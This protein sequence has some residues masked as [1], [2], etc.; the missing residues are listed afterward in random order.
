M[1]DTPSPTEP[2]ALPEID[3]SVP[4]PARMYDYIL[5]GTNNYPADQHMA[6]QLFGAVGMPAARGYARANRLFLGRAVRY[7]VGQGIR[8]FLDVGT[9]I[10][11]EDNVHGVAQQAASDSRIVYV[12]NDPLV[13]VHANALLES[14]SDGA[15]SYISGDLRDPESILL[16]AASTLD[17]AEPV[18]VML[19]GIL[20]MIG[21]EDDPMGIVEELMAAVPSGSYLAMTHMTTDVEPDKMTQVANLSERVDKPLPFAVALRPREGIERF[22]EGLAPVEPGMVR[23]DQWRPEP[24]E[25]TGDV[26]PIY[27][28]VARKP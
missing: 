19:I 8:Q 26:T 1:T 24:D 22:L 10:P 14:T 27:G 23:V 21:D 17:F 6:E 5:G 12:D 18:A 9:G 15:T 11:N 2:R 3:T 20:H 28:V 7:L 13:L 25:P 4:H 16:R